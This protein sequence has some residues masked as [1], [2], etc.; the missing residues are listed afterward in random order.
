[1]GL[2]THQG[3]QPG[4]TSCSMRS[5]ANPPVQA[6]PSPH[7]PQVLSHQVEGEARGTSTQAQALHVCLWAVSGPPHE[8]PHPTDEEVTLEGPGTPEAVRLWL[9]IDPRVPTSTA[10]TGASAVE[11]A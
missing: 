3:P 11:A 7:G 9:G 6:G 10:P 2:L 4:T 5:A 1:M 8:D